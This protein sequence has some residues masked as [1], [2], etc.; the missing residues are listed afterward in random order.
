MIKVKEAFETNQFT[1]FKN[2]CPVL[3]TIETYEEIFKELSEKGPAGVHH[4]V[5]FF[6]TPYPKWGVRYNPDLPPEIWR[7]EIKEKIN[8][9]GSFKEIY[10]ELKEFIP[11]TDQM[12][13][14]IAR[15]VGS[16]VSRHCHDEPTFHINQ[17]GVVEVT[18]WEDEDNLPPTRT[19]ILYPGDAVWLP[20]KQY[21]GFRTLEGPRACVILSY[22]VQ[23][24][25]YGISQG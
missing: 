2:F 16:G 5:E 24:T 22:Q 1:I 3:P 9:L 25:P 14:Q 23:K 20:C 8:R 6:F 11:Q 4:D 21:H 18:T 10:E 12:W 15:E 17:V 7:P 19:E 13:L